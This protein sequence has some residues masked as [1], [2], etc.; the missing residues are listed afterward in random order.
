MEIRGRD[1]SGKRLWWPGLARPSHGDREKRTD[2]DCLTRFQ[3][4]ALLGRYVH[5]HERKAG[6]A[7]HVPILE[8]VHQRSLRTTVRGIA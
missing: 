8:P 5:V 3:S 6:G 7:S 2:A 1:I 4:F